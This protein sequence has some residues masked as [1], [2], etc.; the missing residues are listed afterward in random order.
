M[1]NFK[2]VLEYDGTRFHGWQ[3]QPAVRTVQA[4]LEDAVSDLF[5]E[6]VT[7]NGCCRTDSGVHAWGYVGNFL[8]DST[9]EA[10][11]VWGGLRA[12]LPDDVVVKSAEQVHPDFHARYDCIARRYVYQITTVPAAI[13]RRV[14]WYTQYQLDV[15]LMADAA[16]VFVGEHD[17]TSFA[18]AA[19][20]GGI[21]PVCNV[22]EASLGRDGAVISFEIKANRFLHHMVRNIVGTLIEIGRG[23]FLPEHVEEILRKKDRRIA[24]PTA[25]ACG[26]ALTDVYYPE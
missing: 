25:P 18:P 11:H 23:R 9:L 8:V 1:K 7:V 13:F 15:D 12:K 3:T 20:P 22:L 24:G 16:K 6:K 26:L 21:S 10:T 5:G 17:F 14:L 19:L 2:L 4:V